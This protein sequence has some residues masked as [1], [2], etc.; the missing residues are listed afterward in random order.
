[1][2]TLPS[3]LS[4]SSWKRVIPNPVLWIGCALF[5]T[6]MGRD[7]QIYL[8]GVL[9][10]ALRE[11]RP[12]DA[13][14]SF[15]GYDNTLP[16]HVK[17][18]LSNYRLKECVDGSPSLPGRPQDQNALMGA[19]REAADVGEVEVRCDE[20]PGLALCRF[21]DRGVGLACQSLLRDSDNV[22]PVLFKE[23]RQAG[24]DIFVELD[25]HGRGKLRRGMMSSSRASSA[26]YARAA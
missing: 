11:S 26:A 3:Y 4:G 9:A 22:V 19:W 20:E 8:P 7:V 16:E 23:A 15:V 14:S 17:R 24:R 25:V 12:T 5:N 21:P 10:I 18:L 1:M 13:Y 6:K 2:L